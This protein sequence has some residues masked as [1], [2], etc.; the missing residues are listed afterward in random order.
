M[1]N[2]KVGGIIAAAFIAGAFVA[3]PEL[4]AYA[5]NTVTSAD[6]VNETILSDDIKN[7]QVKNSDLANSAV[8]SSKVKDF[9][10]EAR[11]MKSDFLLMRTAT[12]SDNGFGW[13]PD[14]VD[15]VFVIN[16]PFARELSVILLTVQAPNNGAS[17]ADANCVVTEIE[18]GQVDRFYI[19]CNLAP[20]DGSNLT[21][22]IFHQ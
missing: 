4:R 17:T 18:E 10:L 19:I 9:T 15:K 2:L 16:E 5:A 1:I 14:G 11:D 12:D 7:G 22:V 13:D 3:S 6:I 8:T 21:Y 20:L